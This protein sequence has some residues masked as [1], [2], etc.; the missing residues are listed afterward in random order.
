MDNPDPTVEIE[1][2]DLQAG[3][4]IGG[5]YCILSHI[6]RGGMGHVY[7]VEHIMLRQTYALKILTSDTP[8]ETGWRRFQTEARSIAKLDHPNI[9]KVHN[10]GIHKEKMP[11]YVMDLLEGETLS[12]SI[13]RLGRINPDDAV[14]MF[15]ALCDGLSYA[16]SRGIVHRDI[17][18]SNIMLILQNN[19]VV[20]KLV[21]FGLVK[22]VAGGAL[23]PSQQLTASGEVFG[24]PLYMSPEQ[25]VGRHV[26]ERT[27]IYSLGCT[28]FQALSGAPPFVGENVVQTIMKH[29]FEAPPTLKEASMGVE[30]A[31]EWEAVVART[32][33]K[34]AGDR[35]QSMEELSN[36][37]KAIR[38]G[39]KLRAGALDSGEDLFI[40]NV[41]QSKGYGNPNQHKTTI[42]IAAAVALLGAAGGAVGSFIFLR[43]QQT[44]LNKTKTVHAETLANGGIQTPAPEVVLAER[45]N[46][47]LDDVSKPFVQNGGAIVDSCKSYLFP[48]QSIGTITVSALQ[49]NAKGQPIEAVGAKKIPVRGGITFQANRVCGTHPKIFR[50][51]LPGDVQAIVL[52]EPTPDTDDELFFLNHLTDLKILNLNGSDVSARGLKTMGELPALN[53]LS[54]ARTKNLSGKDLATLKNLHNMIQIDYK[55][56]HEVTPL[57]QALQGSTKIQS[58]FLDYTPLTATDVKLIGQLKSLSELNLIRCNLDA[59]ALASLKSLPHLANLR[60][61]A[62][63]IGPGI[64]NAFKDS[65]TLECLEV[66]INGWTQADIDRLNAIY[67]G[68]VKA[69][70]EEVDKID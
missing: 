66:S 37:L 3:D 43:N 14:D 65:K 58:L 59:S 29:Q 27:D 28:L 8:S 54:L 32:M 6:G 15:I 5:T 17:K 63:N 50:R 69:R 68:R 38:A 47:D 42:I 41:D 48:S 13:R 62:N 39:K 7:E 1:G 2:R 24:S 51:F 18:P 60:I 23:A 57:L 36:D 49:P 56:G 45:V 19:R 30:F 61:S 31:P 11:Y 21:D 4:T 20:P 70:T 10:L 53:V 26:N 25:S 64:V 33:A 46:T 12:A 22:L 52:D 35:Y 34:E 9:V 67:F 55:G 16:H 40:A 44:E